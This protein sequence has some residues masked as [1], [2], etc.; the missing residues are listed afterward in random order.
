VSEPRLPILYL[1]PRVD[2]G[3]YDEIA[4]DWFKHIDRTRWRASLA[5][6]D[7]SPNRGLRELEPFAEEVWDLPDQMAGAAFPEFI[8][9][10]IESRGVR[11]V[12]IMD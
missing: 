10:F 5:T 4:V 9:G 1:V 8:L 7:V 2:L 11:L 12:Q 3:A 6:T